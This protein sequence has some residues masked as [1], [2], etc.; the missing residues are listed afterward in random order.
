MILAL[1]ARENLVLCQFD[2]QTALLHAPIQDEVYIR[3]PAGARHLVGGGVLIFWLEF[4][5]YGV[6][7]ALRAWS[8]HLGEGIR[9]K[10]SA[11]SEADPSLWV[12]QNKV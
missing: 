1:A 3:P 2:V 4:A 10:G 8:R 6:G 7:Q 9:A 12:L 5:L 11:P